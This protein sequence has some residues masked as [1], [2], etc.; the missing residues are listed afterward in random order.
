MDEWNE[1]QT[2]YPEAGSLFYAFF[3]EGFDAPQTR[4]TFD[5][6]TLVNNYFSMFGPPRACIEDQ[7]ALFAMRCASQKQ[8]PNG[9]KF[10]NIF[11]A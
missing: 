1:D 8:V 10:W 4:V 2:H 5:F 7:E 6:L 9:S 3:V 11:L